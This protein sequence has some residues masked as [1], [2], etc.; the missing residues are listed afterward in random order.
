MPP[1]ALRG[2]AAE[3]KETLPVVGFEIRFVCVKRSIGALGL[4]GGFWGCLAMDSS[5]TNRRFANGHPCD[6]VI[7]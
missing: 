4:F 7:W 1:R 6:V 2:P 5:V 3:P